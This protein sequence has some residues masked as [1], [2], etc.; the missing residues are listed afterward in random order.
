MS[1]VHRLRSS[2][3]IFFITSNLNLGETPFEKAEFQIVAETLVKARRH[4]GF[5]L[6]GY[7]LMPDHWHA[8]IYPQHPLAISDVL[9]NVKRVSSL[10]I[11]RLRG[12]GGSRWQHQFWDRFVRTRRNS[13]SASSTCIATRFANAWWNT[14]NSGAG[15]ATT[16]SP[17]T[18][19]LW[20]RARSR[21][22]T[23]ICPTT[24]EREDLV[25]TIDASCVSIVG[26]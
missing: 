18:K 16:I 17:S 23:F 24:T 6:C 3:K 7:V 13:P 4:L 12:T 26:W 25:A 20:L 19:P 22:I 15:P 2:D 14:P 9:Q 8:L 5:L 10:R 11:N 1:N 21:S